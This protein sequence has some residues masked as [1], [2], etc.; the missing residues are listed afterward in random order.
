MRRAG[1]PFSTIVEQASELEAL[2]RHLTDVGRFALDTEFVKERTY[3]AQ[4]G[5]V[6][7]AFD[8]SAVIVD[9]LA[10]GTVE[11]LLDVLVDPG[12]EKVVH[13]AFQDCEV[14]FLGKGKA[15]ANLFDTQIAAALVGYGE[16]ISYA[17]LVASVTGVR[18]AK[19]ETRTDWRRRPLSERQVHYALDDVRY[20]LAVRDHLDERL[21]ATGRRSWALAEFRA[22]ENAGAY[23][24]PEPYQAFRRIEVG[25]L[26]APQRGVLRE[27][28]AW[29]EEQA[30]RRDL[31]R[32][33]IARDSALVEM[34]RRSPKTAQALRRIRSLEPQELDR[35]GLEILERVK[36]GLASPVEEPPAEPE[37]PP[38]TEWLS[39][40]LD[41]WLRS[42]AQEVGIAVSLLGTRD[43]LRAIAAGYLRGRLPERPLLAGWRREV[44]GED[45]LDVLAGRV[46]LAVDPATG[47][48]ATERG[49][50]S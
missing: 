5:T 27:L 23:V 11:P 7:V 20:L 24:E 8:A 38:Q 26:T 13:S 17:R 42:R 47:K 3:F 6:Q 18:L 32:G 10:I 37:D 2:C 4:L 12:I 34:A 22:F 35:S 29:R 43:D 33:W 9:P 46:K 45:L 50:S 40:L 31:P 21:G 28:A 19:L 25:S 16:Q 36:R 48:I 15:P 1:Q 30:R 44:I 39:R 49:G 14:L 41:G